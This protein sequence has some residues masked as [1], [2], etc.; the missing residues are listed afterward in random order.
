MTLALL[1]SSGRLGSRGHA[2]LSLL[3][4]QCL[5]SNSLSEAH[6]KPAKSAVTRVMRKVDLPPTFHSDT[7]A[8]G[9]SFG[10]SFWPRQDI[11][12]SV[13]PP[14]MAAAVRN[15]PPMT[16]VSSTTGGFHPLALA[17]GLRASVRPVAAT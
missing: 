6:A 5:P 17:L 9:G 2:S 14:I 13:R 7:A 1:S 10:S 16:G 12:K 4:P 11:G 15:L 8:V 3:F